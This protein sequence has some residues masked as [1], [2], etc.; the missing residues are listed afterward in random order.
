MSLSSESSRPAAVPA[1]LWPW[2]AAA[3]VLVLAGA[4]LH[5][6]GGQQALF[7]VLQAW[8]EGVPATVWAALSVLG[9]GWS[10]AIVLCALARPGRGQRAVA[11]MVLAAPLAGL[12]VLVGKRL[13][14]VPRPAAVLGE[15]LRVIGERLTAAN[16]MPS[17]H[18]ITAAAVT[19]LILLGLPLRWPQRL[20]VA[21]GGA[22]VLLS[23]VEV[24]AHWPADVLAGA[25]LGVWAALLAWW[26]AAH[27][28]PLRRLATGLEG[29]T[30]QRRLALAELALGAGLVS[31]HTGHPDAAWLPWALAAVALASAV[32]RWRA[33]DPR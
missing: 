25:G 10:G 7:L 21:A 26:A 28:S 2:A 23:R 4:A 32:A 27:W 14:D 8:G 30:G 12:L 17:G 20:L 5:R 13:F 9:L 24:G 16:S 31:S 18:S 29:R 19:A 22:A 1:G 6:A 15:G 33:A 11:A 3:T